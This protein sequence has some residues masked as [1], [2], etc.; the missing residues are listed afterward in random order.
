MIWNSSPPS[1]SSSVSVASV[2][3]SS[4]MR[5]VSPVLDATSVVAVLERAVG[6]PL[7][8][9]LMLLVGVK[10]CKDDAVSVEDGAVCVR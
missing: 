3:I 4:P 7:L 9:W 5:L 10:A 1:S 8:W 6:E 2:S